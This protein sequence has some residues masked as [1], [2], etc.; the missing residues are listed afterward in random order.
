MSLIFNLL[1]TLSRKIIEWLIKWLN[2]S[3]LKWVSRL[4]DFK[5][6]FY[7]ILL[8]GKTEPLSP[9]RLIDGDSSST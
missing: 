1:F 6:W 8:S 5:L 3:I 4:V 2:L 9:T 7:P